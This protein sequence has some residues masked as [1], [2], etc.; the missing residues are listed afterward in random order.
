[1]AGDIQGLAIEIGGE[2]FAGLVAHS[3]LL[4]G[5]LNKDRE[6]VHLFACRATGYPATKRSSVGLLNDLRQYRLPQLVKGIRI[7]EEAGHTDEH[8]L[9]E[10]LAF[11]GIFSQK[12]HVFTEVGYLANAHPALD[13]ADDAGLL[14]G[15]KIEAG[16]SLEQ[17]GELSHLLH[18]VLVLGLRERRGSMDNVGRHFEKRLGE[19]LG[20]QDKISHP[21]QDH[22]FWHARESGGLWRLDQ[23]ETRLLLH[24]ARATCSIAARAGEDDGCRIFPLLIGQR[25]EQRVELHALGMRVILA[26]FNKVAILQ[27]EGAAAREDVDMLELE[28]RAIFCHHH[29]QWC[30]TREDLGEVAFLVLWEMLVNDI[31]RFELLRKGFEKGSERLQ[32]TRRK[33]DDDDQLFIARSLGFLRRVQGIGIH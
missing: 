31:G 22:A 11:G 18:H 23:H 21:A 27:Q 24:G 6:R 19:I 5:L 30:H 8:V 33:P 15:A 16:V 20:R 3:R 7:A 32:T 12:G 17:G 10:I 25:L 14:V 1:M 29:R 2:D 26:G 4:H 9:R 28:W 13:A